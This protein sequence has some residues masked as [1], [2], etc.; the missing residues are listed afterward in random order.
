MK[1]G[2]VL[3]FRWACVFGKEGEFTINITD[4]V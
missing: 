1:R 4:L 2:R 3:G